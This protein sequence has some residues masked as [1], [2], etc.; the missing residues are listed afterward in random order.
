MSLRKVLYGLEYVFEGLICDHV[1]FSN[2]R[3]LDKGWHFDVY[4]RRWH[5]SHWIGYI[6]CVWLGDVCGSAYYKKE[7]P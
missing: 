2:F 5:P 4:V 1:V 3:Q 7:Q 6:R